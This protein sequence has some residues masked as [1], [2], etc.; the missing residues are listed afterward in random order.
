MKMVY[1]IFHLQA[2]T[3]GVRVTKY[4]GVTFS[5]YRSLGMHIIEKV[6]ISPSFVFGA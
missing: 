3:L 6:N 1:T 4:E 2:P 5:H